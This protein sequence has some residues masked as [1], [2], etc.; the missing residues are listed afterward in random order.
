MTYGIIDLGSNTV[1]IALYRMSKTKTLINT[2]TQKETVGLS[3]YIKKNGNMSD[4]GIKTAV[5]I[6]NE[7]KAIARK[8]QVKKLFVIA[9]AVIRNA[10][11]KDLILETLALE[12][13]LVIDC[14]SGEEEAL[15]GV[16]GVNQSYT[17]DKGIIVDIG[18]GST[19]LTLFNDKNIEA[20]V[21]IPIGSLNSYIDHVQ[22][23]LPTK[24]EIE[25]IESS[26]KNHLNKLRKIEGLPIYGLGGTLNA[27]KKLINGSSEQPITYQELKALIKAIKPK[28]KETYLHL[29]QI[30][31]ERLHT[32]MPGLIIIR[33]IFKYF[34]VE[35]MFVSKPGIR[36]GYIYTKFSEYLEE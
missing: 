26:F 8:R 24:K 28:E 34:N 36:E 32:I 1:R 31:P 3:S 5:N 25:A 12:T 29:I 30:V 17:Y 9:T 20:S 4:E 7:F 18:G 13:K 10:N 33:T 23:L 35:E 22:Q 15:Y 6:V 11:N 2:F 27:L 19:E 21:S 14:L 16:Y